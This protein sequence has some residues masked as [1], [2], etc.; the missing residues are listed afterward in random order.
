MGMGME[1]EMEIEMVT[2]CVC[3][4]SY[5]PVISV[6]HLCEILDFDDVSVCHA[7]LLAIGAPLDVEGKTVDVKKCQNLTFAKLKDALG[8]DHKDY[9]ITHGHF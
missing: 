6:G 8:Q 5:R 3:V 2:V 9:G 1:M 7:Y 4:C